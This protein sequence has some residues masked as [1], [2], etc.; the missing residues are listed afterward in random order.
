MRT[1]LSLPCADEQV[2]AEQ[3]DRVH[4]HVRPGAHHFY[5]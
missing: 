3:N 4:A 5:Y 2:C 1:T